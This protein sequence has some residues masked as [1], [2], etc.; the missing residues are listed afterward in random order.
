MSLFV[1]IDKDCVLLFYHSRSFLTST[2][3]HLLSIFWGILER[4]F[5]GHPKGYARNPGKGR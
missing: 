1:L 4:I 5:W 2:I 3:S